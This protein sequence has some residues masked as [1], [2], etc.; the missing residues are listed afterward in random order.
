MSSLLIYFIGICVLLVIATNASDTSNDR[1]KRSI[2]NWEAEVRLNISRG[3]GARESDTPRMSFDNPTLLPVD[4]KE[5]WKKLG[6]PQNHFDANETRKWKQF[7][8][9]NLDNYVEGSELNFL[10]MGGEGPIYES[11]S[12]TSLLWGQ[13]TCQR[14]QLENLK[15]LTIEQA[16]ADA[17]IFIQ[18]INK[19]HNF[20]NPTWIVFG[21]SY[22]GSLSA[23]LRLKF[24]ELVAGAVASSA[25]VELKVDYFE[26]YQ[27]AQNAINAYG[28][29]GCE[30][31]LKRYYGQAEKL[32]KTPEGRRTLGICDN[33]KEFTEKEVNY[34]IESHISHWGWDVQA[35]NLYHGKIASS[36]KA[37][38]RVA[39]WLDSQVLIKEDSSSNVTQ[40]ACWFLWEYKDS[41]KQYQDL[42]AITWYRPW[43]WQICTEM[44]FFQTTSWEGSVFGNLLPIE[45]VYSSVLHDRCADVFG[46]EIN[47][48]NLDANLANLLEI[49]GGAHNY[50]ATNVIF[51]NGSED[52]WHPAGLYEP[53]NESVK[54]IK[55]EGTS[56]CRDMHS[57]SYLDP[58]ALKQAR[59]EIKAE[60]AKWLN[61]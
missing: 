44:G 40:D 17:A 13:S 16:L 30:D 9:Y 8:F 11:Q 21:G 57:P 46:P 49:Y 3:A 61:K 6:S 12:R 28:P 41:V 55:I 51:I 39:D 54:S 27:T 48:A 15:F 7:F 33:G 10:M 24:P 53:P 14:H 5:S 2:K 45:Y 60:I 26:Y 37:A 1:A 47:K 22:P 18:S 25:P 4:W 42:Y 36:C 58:P 29:K 35:D 50:N 43:T 38:V 19:K 56:H 20:T 31:D 23:W 59:E 34:F 52:P 32:I